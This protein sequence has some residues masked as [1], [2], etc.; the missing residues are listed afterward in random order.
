ML[1][2]ISPCE[3]N[4]CF[5]AVISGSSRVKYYQRKRQVVTVVT[6]YMP[7]IPITR[8]RPLSKGRAKPTR[9]GLRVVVAIPKVIGDH[10]PVIVN[11]NDRGALCRHRLRGI[12]TLAAGSRRGA[13][14]EAGEVIIIRI[15][16]GARPR[17][18]PGIAG[19]RVIIILDSDLIRIAAHCG[20]VHGEGGA[21]VIIAFAFHL[22]EP[23]H[24]AVAR[25][26]GTGPFA[27]DPGVRS[28][29]RTKGEELTSHLAVTG[30]RISIFGIPAVEGIARTGG[31]LGSDRRPADGDELGFG[32]AGVGK[33]LFKDEPVTLLGVRSQNK[34]LLRQ[35]KGRIADLAKDHLAL[36]HRLDLLP[37]HE[38]SY[39][40]FLTGGI[41]R[42][43]LRHFVHR[44]G[45]L[46][47]GN[48]L[49]IN[50]DHEAALIQVGNRVGLE[51]HGIVVQLIAVLDSAV[52][53]QL[54]GHLIANV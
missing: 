33:V 38:L 48:V 46:A 24:H 11:I 3:I 32:V 20:I 47:N 31:V 26:C 4:G 44:T 37:A 52:F 13:E 17:I 51:G 1:R 22:L 2:I 21:G 10:V 50:L 25:P 45:G 34:A 54:R 30:I 18:H 15:I 14:M 35:L 39:D 19:G 29:V 7:H 53:I 40:A 43:V 41:G 5:C 36:N 49:L 6:T 23:E 16:I 27:V 42:V 8:I 12:I 9:E 28:D